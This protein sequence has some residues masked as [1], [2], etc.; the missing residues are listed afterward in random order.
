MTVAAVWV[1]LCIYFKTA[2]DV[3]VEPVGKEVLRLL[4]EGGGMKKMLKM[5]KVVGRDS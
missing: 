1:L 3:L 4:L 5:L 2:G